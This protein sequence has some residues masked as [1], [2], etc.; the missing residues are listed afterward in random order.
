M[1][2]PLSLQPFPAGQLAPV[3]E[4]VGN[5]EEIGPDLA[6]FSLQLAEVDNLFRVERELGSATEMLAVESL[7]LNVRLHVDFRFVVE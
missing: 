4:I 7:G 1:A 2:G 6:L 5:R 3:A